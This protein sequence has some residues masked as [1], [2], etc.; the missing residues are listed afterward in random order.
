MADS[1]LSDGSVDELSPH[2]MDAANQNSSKHFSI[3]GP[4][5]M[6]DFVEQG[7]TLCSFFDVASEHLQNIQLVD[8]V[9]LD[10]LTGKAVLLLYTSVAEG[11]HDAIANTQ[12]AT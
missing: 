9:Q 1:L 7:Q 2:S 10:V 6:D 3:G 11:N 8:G 12:A 5:T 4:R